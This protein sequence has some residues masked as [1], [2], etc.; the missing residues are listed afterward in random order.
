[1]PMR[2]AADLRLY[3]ITDTPLSSARGVVETAMA[4]VRGGATLVQLRDPL[5]K[6]GALVRLGRELKAALDTVG[7]PLIV[8]DRPDIA[9]AIGAAGVHIGQDD[10]PPEA[11][12]RLLGPDAIIGL[13]VTH[14]SEMARV[15]W[16]LIDHVGVGPVISRGVKPDAAAP[17]GLEALS[18]C[19][20]ASLKPVVA[21]GGIGLANAA[22]CIAAG[23]AG[24]AVVAAISGTHDPEVAARDLRHAVDQALNAKLISAE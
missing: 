11:A 5:A 24:V 15:P 17:M 22:E 20:M 19:V 18:A 1:M 10:L 6:A 16:G 21:I 12:R 9:F 23:A 8:N 3:H 7:I 14:L 2:Q 4:A 13:S